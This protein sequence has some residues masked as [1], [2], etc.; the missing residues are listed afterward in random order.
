MHCTSLINARRLARPQGGGERGGGHH[1]HGSGGEGDEAELVAGR[2]CG[3]RQARRPREGDPVLPLGG[4][5]ARD[6]EQAEAPAGKAAA[7]AASADA[8]TLESQRRWIQHA[9]RRAGTGQIE[10]Q[11]G[12]GGAPTAARRVGGRLPRRLPSRRRLARSV[13]RT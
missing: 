13:G 9:D 8:L 2:G 7:H 4:A 12:G 11:D 3:G 5:V 1:Q 10:A 6:A